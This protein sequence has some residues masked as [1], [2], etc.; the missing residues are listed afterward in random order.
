MPGRSSSSSSS[1]RS[2]SYGSSFRSNSYGSSSRPNSY[3]SS[4]KSNS[5][6]SSSRKQIYEKKT[7]PPPAQTP[8]PSSQ[9]INPVQS[10]GGGFFS[11]ITQGF[12]FGIGSSIAH[13]VVGGIFGSSTNNTN[14][15]YP[16]SLDTNQ[17]GQI[18]Q[19]S[20]L[21]ENTDITDITKQNYIS[22]PECARL[23]EEYFNCL[24][25]ISSNENCNFSL[26]I[27]KDCEDYKM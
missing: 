7:V 26:N 9:P 17:N 5:Y 12:G 23:Q 24:K 1:S 11:S 3:S 25:N 22:K 13:R 4:S 8:L 21:L 2:N 16:L 19:N 18:G 10:S 14:N 27:F 6:G 20:Q 15:S